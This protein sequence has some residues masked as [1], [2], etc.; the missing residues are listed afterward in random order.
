MRCS[1]TR[2]QVLL[3]YSEGAIWL[4]KYKR[5]RGFRTTEFLVWSILYTN[6]LI[7]F[8]QTCSKGGVTGTS[9]L[10]I[11][12]IRTSLW[13]CCACMLL[14]VLYSFFRLSKQ[15][16]V[17]F[18]LSHEFHCQSKVGQYLLLIRINTFIEFP[19]NV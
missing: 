19:L 1:Y 7:W 11:E 16:W 9:E 6:N 2:K 14:S 3:L 13:C 17:K 10:Y 18:N 4:A 12:I 8:I 15:Y 5:W